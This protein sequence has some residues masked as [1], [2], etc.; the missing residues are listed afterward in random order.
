MV[1]RVKKD[2]KFIEKHY[3]F[4]KY[5]SAA[6][7]KTLM[8]GGAGS[9][10]SWSIAQYLLFEK[11]YKEHD[12][13]I[14]VVRFTL[15]S[16]RTSALQ[17]ILDQ[18]HR[19][20]LP[21]KYNKADMRITHGSNFMIFRSLDDVEKIKSI[22]GINY[23]WIE[24]AT[25]IKFFDFMQLDLRM[26]APNINP[27]AINRMLL[28]FN[29][30][31]VRSFLKPLTENPD[32]DMCVQHST[33]RD[34]PFLSAH[35]VKQL[36]RLIKQDITYHKIY[37]KGEWASPGNIIYTNWKI[38][39][40][41]PRQPDRVG[42]GLDFGF[43]NPTALIEIAHRDTIVYERELIYE[44]GMTNSQLINKLKV[45]IPEQFRK[46]V[47]KADCA[48][49]DRIEEIFHEGFNIHPC[50][51]GKDSVKIGIDR[52]K[53][54][55]I[56]IFHTSVNLIEEKESYK[57]KVDK[58]GNI[59]DEPVQ[60]KDHLMDGERYYLGELDMVRQMFVEIGSYGFTGKRT[61]TYGF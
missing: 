17:L 19:Y 15:P 33:Y 20:N 11:F 10:K 61:G 16:L 29:P 51:K 5:K 7:R 23:I 3:N 49:P 9:G 4:L 26:R 30:V 2:V 18:L 48:A 25:E 34:N 40:F 13:G 54:E 8:Y 39:Q 55:N 12:I 41:W 35:Y 27:G 46:R 53:R 60:W 1:A 36:E 31:D 43:N 37:N 45:A 38:T 22:E 42:Y 58:Y 21:H 52:V 56:R 47:I 32:E 59:L 24:E 28:S 44:T 6:F 50:K 14:L 57:W